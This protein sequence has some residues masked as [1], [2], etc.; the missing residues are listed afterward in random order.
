MRARGN[1]HFRTPKQSLH[2]RTVQADVRKVRDPRY[3]K[4]RV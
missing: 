3:N 2:S 1:D 4:V